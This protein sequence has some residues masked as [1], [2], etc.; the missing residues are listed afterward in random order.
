MIEI[1]TD[2]MHRRNMS[3][4]SSS[5]SYTKNIP[6]HT[7]W[8]CGWNWW[9]LN[10]SSKSFVCS[11]SC[12]KLLR[13]RVLCIFSSKICWCDL[14]VYCYFRFYSSS[15]AGLKRIRNVKQRTLLYKWQHSTMLLG[16]WLWCI[17]CWR[18][19][20]DS[21]SEINFEPPN[22]QLKFLSFLWSRVH[23]ASVGNAR[24]K[25]ADIK[26]SLNFSMNSNYQTLI[27]SAKLQNICL[28]SSIPH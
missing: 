3:W 23:I 9:N 5:L 13:G 22:R 18:M 26:L 25:T 11:S 7:A 16:R 10:Y 20:N 24:F 27:F 4:M 1:C 6:Q 19:P 8:V 2:P 28:E 15:Y 12:K 17:Q 14:P 21:F